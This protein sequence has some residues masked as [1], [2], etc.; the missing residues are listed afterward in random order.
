MQ[1]V[2]VDSAEEL[3]LVDALEDAVL[4]V[5]LGEPCVVTVVA[6]AYL[7]IVVEAA[8]ALTAGVAAAFR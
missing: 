4:A 5:V 8:A 7:D 2:L 6:V 3:D 1:L